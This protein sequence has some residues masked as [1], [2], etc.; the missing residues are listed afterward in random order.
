M[1]ENLKWI[2][3]TD[4]PVC[5]RLHPGQTQVGRISRGCRVCTACRFEARVHRT[6]QRLGQKAKPQNPMPY[7]NALMGEVAEERFPLSLPPL[8]SSDVRRSLGGRAF[9]HRL[10]SARSREAPPP[11]RDLRRRGP[12][13]GGPLRAR[14][15]RLEPFKVSPRSQEPARVP[16]RV[17]KS[18]RP[19]PPPACKR[20]GGP[21]VLR[22]PR[23]GGPCGCEPCPPPM[24]RTGAPT[25]RTPQPRRWPEAPR[26]GGAG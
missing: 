21:A 24:P 22:P 23:T 10:G 15:E 5:C 8:E 1:A 16:K 9:L 19:P 13:P 14:G 11:P 6:I 20:P 17:G 25:G 18:C 12:L 2:E 7:H 26:P 3:L 4:T